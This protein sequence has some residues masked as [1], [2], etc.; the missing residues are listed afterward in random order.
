MNEEIKIPE[1]NAMS[2]CQ[3]CKKDTIHV[4]HGYTKEGK[5]WKGHVCTCR[6]WYCGECN[7]LSVGKESNEHCR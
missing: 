4:L 2:Y 7:N 3:T 6:N 5:L 1:G